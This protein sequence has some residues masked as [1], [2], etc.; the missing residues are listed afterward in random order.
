MLPSSSLS[1]SDP[2]QVYTDLNSLQ[3]INKL[4]RSDKNAALM[5]VA[6]QFES[7]FLNMMLSS[8]RKA[9]AVFEED[10]MLNSPESNFFR[11]MYD[12]QM[13]VS[14]ADNGATGLAD[15]IYRQL[16][17]SYGDGQQ[18][19]PELDFSKISDRRI[20]TSPALQRA[21]DTVT[22]V[23]ADGG[24]N[25]AASGKD[26]PAGTA[27]GNGN[28]GQQ[29]ASVEE[30]V[31]TLYPL[32]EKV[33]E[34]IGVD[35]KAVVA[36]AALETGWGK[37]MITDEQGRNSFNFFGIKADSRWSGDSVTVITHEYRGGS[38]VKENA[39]FRSYASAEE[40][41]NDYADFLSRSARYE[42][43]VGRNLGADQYG[44]ELQQ[45]GYATDPRYGE[46][47]QRIS[48]GDLLNDVWQKIQQLSPAGDSADG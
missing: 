28:K 21:M 13:A 36:Q 22:Q 10:S 14:L 12:N 7:M 6:E 39:A 24:N 19:R 37:Y 16:M 42:N 31:A 9:N 45:S 1:Q 43:A 40:G 41:L 11:N 32:A 38:A 29:F 4:G 8:M 26:T 5:K 35:P 2:G 17:D 27:S 34:R 25:N 47:I 3:G 46:K 18:D 15:V 48:E 23:V 20:H 33:A 44:H 30:F